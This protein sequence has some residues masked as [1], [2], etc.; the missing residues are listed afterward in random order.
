MYWQLR[1]VT[2]RYVLIVPSGANPTLSPTDYC[3]IRWP[4]APVCRCDH[5]PLPRSPCD[6]SWCMCSAGDDEDGEYV[7]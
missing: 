5:A 6:D 7:P 3:L 1:R 4:E 2:S